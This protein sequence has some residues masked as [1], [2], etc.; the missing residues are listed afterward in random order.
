MNIVLFCHS[1]LSDW[2]HGNAH[3]LR[4]I[5]SE[6]VARGHSFTAYEP[7][8]AWSVH[9]LIAERGALPEDELRRVYPTLSTVRYDP[10][11]LDLDQALNGANLVVVHEWNPPEL[12][13]AV[14]RHRRGGGRYALLFHDTH[15]RSVTDPAAMSALDLEGYDAVLAFGEAI[16]AKY[17]EAGWARRVFT[18]HEAADPRVFHPYPA[19]VPESDVVWIGNWGDGE[20]T[21]ELRE[22]LFEPVAAEH[23]SATVYGVRYPA[24]AITE[25][26][27]AGIVYGGFIANY[28]APDAFARHRVTMHVPRGPYTRSL[29][30]IPTIRVFEALACGIP[31]VSAPWTDSEGLFRHGDYRSVRDGGETRAALR[32]LLSDESARRELAKRGRETVLG[33]HTCAHRVDQL[34]GIVQKLGFTVTSSQAVERMAAS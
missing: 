4:G 22:F 5:A 16:R 32:E 25:L 12:I 27:H 15:H 11:A 30:G 34:F 9:N 17:E 8:D 6:C 20:R 14:G 13:S 18:W 31:L 24:E 19:I 23:A 1:L 10:A 3:F 28:R 2:N 33:R 21:A 7:V 29:P 26:R